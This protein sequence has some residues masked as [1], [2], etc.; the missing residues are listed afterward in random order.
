MHILR[1]ALGADLRCVSHRL[2]AYHEQGLR[3]NMR[4]LRLRSWGTGRLR[5][6]VKG[7]KNT[8]LRTP[9]VV[10]SLAKECPAWPERPYRQA[11]PVWAGSLTARPRKPGEGAYPPY[12]SCFRPQ[13]FEF[14]AYLVESCSL[15][16]GCE[17]SSGDAVFPPRPPNIDAQVLP[18][19]APTHGGRL[20]IK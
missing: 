6:G 10:N 9:T 7:Y 11:E 12:P 2:N 15:A 5:L 4:R 1:R 14:R 17:R 18:L 19:G 3:Q 16:Q 13:A 8:F 20:E